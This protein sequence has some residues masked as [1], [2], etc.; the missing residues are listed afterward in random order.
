MKASIVIANAVC[1]T[2]DHSNV[3]EWIAL[4]GEKILALGQGETYKEILSDWD[5]FID[6]KKSTV[7]P[8]F[9]D[10]HFHVVQTALNSQCV[11]LG[12]AKSFK[13]IG[14]RIAARHQLEPG[15][16]IHAIRL[17]VQN[18]KERRLPVRQ[19]LDKMCS[20]SPIW[21]NSNEYQTSVLN[22]Y[23]LLYYK[24]PFTLQGVQCDDKKMPTGIFQ[25]QANA[26]LRANISNKYSDFYRLDALQ[27]IMPQIAETGITTVCAVEGGPI[28]CDKD[29][30]FINEIIK[31]KSIYLDMELF[32]QTLDLD[33]VEAMGLK[34]V[35]GCLYVDGTF[36]ARLAAVSFE[37]ADA[38]GETGCLNFTQARMNEFVEQC[39]RRNLQLSLY[40]IG[41]R[42]IEM[43]LKAHERAVALTGIVGLRHRLEHVELPT[44]EHIEM[45]AKM[46]ILF[47]VRPI[48]EMQWGGKGKM[49]EK[50]LGEN[51]K[52]TNPFRQ[53]IDGG[54]LAC[55]GTDSDVCK[56]N[57][58]YG[59]HAAVNHPV[60]EHRI[61]VDE[62]I[63]MFTSNGAYA[64]G[65]ENEKGKLKEG[66]MADIVV[67]DGDILK[68]NPEEIKNLNVCFTIK[69]GEVVY[70]A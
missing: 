27:N 70:H 60:K 49:Y 34:R 9:I 32:F 24:I 53:I 62:A 5:V 66:Y 52:R 15:K 63:A 4:S 22:T 2:Q 45:A 33:R 30:E 1:L 6:A 57:I 50:R 64:I 19:D 58:I 61:N 11:D 46:G 39:Y 21:I 37:Y 16:P 59:I 13:D 35:G 12:D 26:L 38:P 48:Y 42:A 8:G 44:Q 41:D 31:R 29:A 25:R 51:Y 18:L 7:L 20:D 55:G 67:L 14:E 40:T 3:C 47:S 36:S 17:D 23:A 43:S 54:V 10:S 69:A 28:Y 68:T 56:A 65:K